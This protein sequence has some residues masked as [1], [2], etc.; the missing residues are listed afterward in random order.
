ML[1]T[2]KKKIRTVKHS[3]HTYQLVTL[4][5]FHSKLYSN[6]QSLHSDAFQAFNEKREEIKLLNI[7][8]LMVYGLKLKMFPIFFTLYSFWRNETG[9]TQT[10]V[11]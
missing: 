11:E 6:D 1:M 2:N 9:S 8:H 5:G 10:I 3:G 4:V 7:M